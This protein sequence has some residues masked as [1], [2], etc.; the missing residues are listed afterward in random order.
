MRQGRKFKQVYIKYGVK[1]SLLFYTYLGVFVGIFF[2]AAS[3][4]WLEEH[5]A[6]TAEINGNK[7]EIPCS[8]AL[9]LLDDRIY[10]YSDRNSEVLRLNVES[11]EYTD[12]VMYIV[13]YEN[14]DDIT[15]NVTVEIISGKSTLLRKIFMK[16]GT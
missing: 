5:E 1:S 8:S 10:L 3:K 15:G 13:L 16:A 7:I 6:Y 4:I 9:N 11:T 2:I 14:I 12:G